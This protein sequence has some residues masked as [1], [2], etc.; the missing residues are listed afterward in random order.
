MVSPY[1]DIFQG[2]AWYYAR[3]R[4]GY[5]PEFFDLIKR[6]FDLLKGDRVL[7]LGCGTGQIAIPISA[8]VKEVVAMDP[9]PEMISEGNF[10]PGNRVFRT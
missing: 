4:E 9:E 5:P 2:T 8:S 6:K 10:R 7:D 3:F 1:K